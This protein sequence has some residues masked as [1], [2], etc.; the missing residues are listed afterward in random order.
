MASP[1]LQTNTPRDDPLDFVIS[2][3]SGKDTCTA[4]GRSVSGV[5]CQNH[6][7]AAGSSGLVRIS[8]SAK[9]GPV[10]GWS[11]ENCKGEPVVVFRKSQGCTHF[12]RE[13]K[14]WIGVAPEI[15]PSN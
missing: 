2:L 3:F 1:T 13:I 11:E 8:V 4:G 5:G 6:T 9:D 7:L 12:D 10:T 14:S 15:V